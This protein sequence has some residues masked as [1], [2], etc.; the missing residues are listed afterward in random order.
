MAYLAYAKVGEVPDPFPWGQIEVMNERGE[1][2][3]LVTEVNATE[4]W[5][6]RY[7]PGPD[8]QPYFDPDD[9]TRL[10]MERLTGKFTI[11]LNEAPA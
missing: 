10:A 9:R 2:V 5:L 8:G 3:D 4:G 11:I 1:I 7:K 6:V